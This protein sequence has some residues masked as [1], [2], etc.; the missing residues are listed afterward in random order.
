[1]LAENHFFAPA[2][3]AAAADRRQEAINDVQQHCGLVELL[4]RLMDVQCEAFCDT[5]AHVYCIEAAASNDRQLSCFTRHPD[6][7]SL[8]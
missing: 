1:M 5:T 3:A 2:D 7:L 4:L 6:Y 8:P